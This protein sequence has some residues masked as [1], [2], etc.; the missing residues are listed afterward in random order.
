[1]RRGE[2]RATVRMPDGRNGRSE[3]LRNVA[4]SE[5]TNER[6]R[7]RSTTR[8]NLQD[9]IENEKEK[10]NVV[11]RLLDPKGRDRQN[12]ADGVGGELSAL[13]SRLQRRGG[14]LRPSATLRRRDARTRRGAGRE[15]RA[16]QT[17]GARAVLDLEKESVSG[18]GEQGDR[19]RRDG[20]NAVGGRT[21]TRTSYFSTC[22]ARRT[23]KAR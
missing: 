4:T 14:G 22:P 18:R 20:G 16:L 15:R 17:H 6:T 11:P 8:T 3:K 10:E 13:R 19:R 23:A 1:M 2:T 21:A 5:R 12:D 7:R 9:D